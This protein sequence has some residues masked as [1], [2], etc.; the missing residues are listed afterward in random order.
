M[1]TSQLSSKGF[2][3]V[4]MM[5]A[6]FISLL[7]IFAM[8]QSIDLIAN[9]NSQNQMR[10][11]AVKLADDKLKAMQEGAFPETVGYIPYS[12]VRIGNHSY[13]VRKSLNVISPNSRELIVNVKWRYKNLS[14]HHEARSV[15]SR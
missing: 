15:K 14:T 10:D 3:L 8:L 11:E 1:G 9:T 2:T 7:G 5:I 12:T 6:M 13:L 4:E